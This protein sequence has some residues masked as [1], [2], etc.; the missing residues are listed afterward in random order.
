MTSPLNKQCK[1]GP[2]SC[3]AFPSLSPPRRAAGM[4]GSPGV[5]LVPRQP[6]LCRGSQTKNIIQNCTAALDK[7]PRWGRRQEGE[8]Q[9]SDADHMGTGEVGRLPSLLT[10]ATSPG[11]VQTPTQYRE[12]SQGFSLLLP[13]ANEEQNNLHFCRRISFSFETRGLYLER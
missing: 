9:A 10:R 6:I 12:C 4:P 2:F 3:Q 1:H 5:P 8:C 7:G 11:L 13:F